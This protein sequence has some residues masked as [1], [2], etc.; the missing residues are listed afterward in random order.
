MSAPKPIEKI[1]NNQKYNIN[2][3]NENLYEISFFLTNTNIYFEVKNNKE[4]F[5]EIYYNSFNLSKLNEMCKIFSLCNSLK[6]AFDFI[7]EFFKQEKVSIRNIN[8]NLN[9]IMVIPIMMKEQEVI[10]SL[11]KKENKKDD[12]IPQICDVMKE[13]KKE[14]SSLK[15]RIS[16][17]ETRKNERNK[18]WRKKIIE[19]KRK[20][21]SLIMTEKKQRELIKRKF[22]GRGKTINF[23]NLLFRASRNRDRSSVVHNKIDGKTEILM[24]VETTK[25]SKFGGYTQLGFDSS[26]K[27]KKDPQSFLFS[28]DKNKTYDNIENKYSTVY[29][30]S[31]CCPCFSCK[32]GNFNIYIPNKFYSHDGCTT[33]KGNGY[34][35]TEDYELNGGEENFRVKELEYFQINYN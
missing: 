17:L 10:F 26:G 23:L 27:Q 7:N 33:T 25:G 34:Y 3:N 12:L 4:I 15:E 30:Y 22:E 14:I 20:F 11:K 16:E 2:V 28:F 18:Q 31:D 13:M 21:P 9:I 6:E 24:I 32:S 8:D 35:T 5:P 1:E 29:C 19:E